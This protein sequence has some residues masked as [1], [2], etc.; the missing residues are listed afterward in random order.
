[1]KVKHLCYCNTFR[2]ILNWLCK[3]YKVSITHSGITKK[4]E[5]VILT[6]RCGH[7]TYLYRH[8]N[9]YILRKLIRYLGVTL[10]YRWLKRRFKSNTT[11][12][13]LNTC[14][15]GPFQWKTRLLSS[16]VKPQVIYAALLATSTIVTVGIIVL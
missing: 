13:R 10:D 6:M 3:L 16:V 1:M 5:I 14:I 9:P 8:R 2:K 4:S 7:T 11:L 12:V 15:K